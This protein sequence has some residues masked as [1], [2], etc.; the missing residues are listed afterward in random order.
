MISPDCGGSRR[1]EPKDSWLAL[2]NQKLQLRQDWPSGFILRSVGRVIG[3]FR[4]VQDEERV[5]EGE[6]LTVKERNHLN[7]PWRG[8]SSG[9][10]CRWL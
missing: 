8:R 9:H 4:Q 10:R 6:V 3:A 7:L 2:I 5:S 1:Q